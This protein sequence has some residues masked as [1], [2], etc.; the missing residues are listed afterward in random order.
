MRRLSLLLVLPVIAGLVCGEAAALSKVQV[1]GTQVALY[2]Y[3]FYKGEIDG[4]AGPL[5][6][7]A[8]RRFQRS[9]GL[10][11]D[12]V[13]GRRTRAAFGRRF[14]GPLFGTRLL[15][16]GKTG[17]DVSV[18][19]F[20]LA[21]RGLPVSLDGSFGPMTERLVRRFQRRAGL[22]PDGIVGR[23]TRAALL[24]SRVQTQPAAPSS[25][26]RHVVRPGETLSSIAAQ[27]GTTVAALARRNGLN[28]NRFLL[29]G[30][31]LVVPQGGGVSA[32]PAPRAAVEASLGRWAAHYG[33]SL[34]LVRALAWHESGFQNHVRSSAGA[35]GV[36]QVLP[37]TR[38]FV[39]QVLIGQRVPRTMDGN[40]RVGVAYLHHLLHLFGQDARLALGAYYSGPAAVMRRGLSRPTRRFVANVLALRGRV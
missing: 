27:A 12:G 31:R 9:K 10:T 30:T 35:V 5:T 40:V 28:P 4:I 6:R 16:R 29:I 24:N 38:E 3:G 20:L 18:L 36:M 14:G 1:P 13:V 32:A 34:D 22:H 25:G 19:Q 11:P 2:R 15:E 8:I 37:V 33:V 7:R 23:R 21:R 39:E 26:P 17:F